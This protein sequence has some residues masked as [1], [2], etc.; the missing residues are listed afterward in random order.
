MLNDVNVR[1]FLCEVLESKLQRKIEN[2]QTLSLTK[3]CNYSILEV[4]R[5]LLYYATAYRSLWCLLMLL[6]IMVIII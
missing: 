5:H 1:I 2:S 6:E 3:L 4:A